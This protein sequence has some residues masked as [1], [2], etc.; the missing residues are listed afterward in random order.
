MTVPPEG[1]PAKLRFVDQMRGIAI[2]MVVVVH[3]SQSFASPTLKAAGMVGQLGV[4]L[5]FVASAFTLCLS[6][7]RREAERDAV[8]NFYIRRFFR[9]MPLYYIGIIFYSILFTVLGLASNYTFKN[10]LSNVL[11]IHGFVPSANNTIV[12]GGWSIGVEMAFY[13]MFPWLF[14]LIQRLQQ[15]WGVLGLLGM[16]LMTVLVVAAAQILHFVLTKSWIENN[17]FWYFFIIL[18]LP[19]FGIGFLLYFGLYQDPPTVGSWVPAMLCAIGLFSACEIILVKDEGP[20]IA[21]L[22]AV[23]GIASLALAHALRSRNV[24]GSWLSNLGKVSFS[25][26]VIHFAVVW[27]PTRFFIRSLN[28]DTLMEGIISLPLLI[29]NV[30]IL[31]WLGRLSWHV[32][33][34]PGNRAAR[35]IIA[36]LRS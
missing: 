18:Q 34:E 32:V 14:S 29:V 20:L 10:I 19:A 4:Q 15:R 12:P 31:Y 36:R 30:V 13:V 27:G 23:A 26:Y 7:D 33:E 25:V 5:F 17:T 22:P 1:E 24:S 11:F 35:R 9:I 3:Y 21:F 8:R 28:G 2:L 16:I 6:M